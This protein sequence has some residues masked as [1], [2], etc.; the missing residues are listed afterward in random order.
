MLSYLVQAN[1]RKHDS[2]IYQLK[3]PADVVDSMLGG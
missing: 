2:D 1:Q 3:K